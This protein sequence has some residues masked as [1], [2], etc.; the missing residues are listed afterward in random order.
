[1]NKGIKTELNHLNTAAP[2]LPLSLP[3]NRGGEL[4][5]GDLA[6]DDSY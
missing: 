1:M 4:A 6:S 2:P 3:S 5:T